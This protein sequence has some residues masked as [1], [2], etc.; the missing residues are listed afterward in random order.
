MRSTRVC[1]FASA[2]TALWAVAA[3]IALADAPQSTRVVDP[4]QHLARSTSGYPY[5]D[6]A[7]YVLKELDLKPGDV[8]VDIGAGDGWWSERMGKAVG[9]EGT[10]HA[11]EVEQK[12]VDKMKDHG[13]QLSRVVQEAE[14]S[15]WV[16]VRCELI[17]GTEHFL[18]IF[19][20]K[21]LFEPKK[22]PEQS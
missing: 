3:A 15:G 18:A 17:T 9:P 10:V 16:P 6:K 13:M 14:E 8:V 5:R 19:V 11:A 1:T 4:Q 22:E 7:D 21:D 20:Q 12:L 2:G